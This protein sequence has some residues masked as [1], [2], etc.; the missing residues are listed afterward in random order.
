[1]KNVLALAGWLVA[2]ALLVG[3]AFV[4][5]SSSDH[6]SSFNWAGLAAA[7]YLVAL[8]LYVM[9]KPFTPR[10]SAVTWLCFAGAAAFVCFGWTGMEDQSKWQREKLGSIHTLILRGV[11]QTDLSVPLLRT[12]R[13]YHEQKGTRRE[14]L[15]KTFLR[16]APQ[17]SVGASIHFKG[18]EGDSMK[19]FVSQLSDTSV[20][21]VSEYGYGHGRNPE[22]QNYDGKKGI[23][24]AKATLTEKGVRYETE[25]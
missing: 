24:Q 20:T 11:Y 18:W 12:L 13:S 5:G 10:T 19:T 9:R 1:M 16:I 3:G 25:N 2:G 8:L 23:P 22:F 4:L 15:G 6:W 21:L 7:A 14:T 17:G